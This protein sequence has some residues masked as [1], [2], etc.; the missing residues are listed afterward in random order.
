MTVFAHQRRSAAPSS[1]VREV[2]VGPLSTV[3]GVAERFGQDAT[4]LVGLNSAGPNRSTQHHLSPVGLQSAVSM[5]LLAAPI[6][7]FV[8]MTSP[9][10]P[11]VDSPY[12][13]GWLGAVSIV[14][15]QY[16]GHPL[17]TNM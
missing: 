9:V 8:A 12:G 3:A 7:P 2:V 4:H 1:I 16:A 17:S 14:Q 5:Q 11:V 13:T 15:G 10:P 6:P